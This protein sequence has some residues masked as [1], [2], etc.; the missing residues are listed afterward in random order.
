MDKQLLESL[1]KLFGSY[2]CEEVSPPENNGVITDEMLSIY[3]EYTGKKLADLITDLAF[4]LC[5]SKIKPIKIQLEALGGLGIARDVLTGCLNYAWGKITAMERNLETEDDKWWFRIFE[6]LCLATFDNLWS[7]DQQAFFKMTMKH[8]TEKNVYFISYTNRL[9]PIINYTYFDSVCR[10]IPPVPA[11][12]EMSG[13]RNLLAG[14][15]ASWLKIKNIKR[16]FY[17]RKSL[18]ISEPIDEV[19][20]Q[21][22]KDSLFLI[23]LIDSASLMNEMTN[24]SFEEYKYYFQNQQRSQPTAMVFYVT[25]ATALPSR[26]DY[27]HPDYWD[28]YRQMDSVKRV[29]FFQEINS[30][31][32]F[33][34][35]MEALLEKINLYKIAWFNNA[36]N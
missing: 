9:A 33:T 4:A 25:E 8:I 36:P 7:A 23:Q 17:D 12:A 29:N 6:P 20:K 2:P 5:V 34:T 32:S 31:G 3:E 18:R 13:S 28:W 21:N 26:L 16:G 30:L 15:I 22:C 10:Y 11:A 19:L 14:S 27:V 24:W 1:I 35:C